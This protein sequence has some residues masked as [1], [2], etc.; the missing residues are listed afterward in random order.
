MKLVTAD[1]MRYLDRQ[2]VKA[3][4]ATATLMENAGLGVAQ[5]ARKLLGNVKGRRILVL[6]GPG[7][8]GGDGLVAARHLYDWGAETRVYLLAKRLGDDEN[9][10]Q[11]VKREL[12]IADAA[13]DPGFAALDR[14][15][16]DAD[17]VVDALLGTGRARPIEANLAEI[18]ERVRRARGRSQ[19]PRLVAV[20]IPTGVDSDTGAVDPHCVPAD[21]TVTFAFSKI[22]LHTLP[23]S[24]YAGRVEV[25]DIGVPAAVDSGA[26]VELIT[27]EWVA[28]MLPPRPLNANKGTF[29]R[30][31]VVGGSENYVGALRL[32][33]AAALRVGAGRVTVACPQSIQGMIAAGL[34]EATYLPL[35]ERDGGIAEKA[36]STVLAQME[37][38]DVLLVGCGLGRR[39]GTEAFLRSLLF[40]LKGGAKLTVVVDADGL[41]ALG[42]VPGWPSRASVPLVLTPHPGELQRLTGRSVA[43]IQ[44]DRLVA[45]QRYAAEWKQTLVLKGA[46]TVVAAADGRAAVSPF[47]NPA[48]ATAG[49]GDVLAGVIA[50]LLAQGLERFVAAACG[51]YLHGAAGER[52]RES[53]GDAGAVAGDLLPELPAVIKALK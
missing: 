41:N 15:I 21:L 25:V 30:V 49:T 16:A 38:F 34:V 53:I 24:Q 48:L 40:A 37:D 12:D 14:F 29:G 13:D 52:V 19:P 2:A 35:A 11:L 9:Y 4:V 39:G 31:L 44:S 22:G 20:D 36:V 26:K 28:R 6:A 23:G 7:N 10:R 3:G 46:H 27:P 47:A 45:A 5:H 32:A 33:A 51:V 18:L 42:G 1:Q 8:N 17:M 43:E 50:G